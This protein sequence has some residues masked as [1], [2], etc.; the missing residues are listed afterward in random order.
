MRYWKFIPN[1]A[2][3]SVSCPIYLVWSRRYIFDLYSSGDGGVGLSCCNIWKTTYWYFLSIFNH[4]IQSCSACL[5]I[6]SFK[7]NIYLEDNSEPFYISWFAICIK[8]QSVF[9][10]SGR[11][12]DPD[13]KVH[14]ANIRPTWVLSAPDGPHVGPWNL[15]SGETYPWARPS[16]QQLAKYCVAVYNH[17]SQINRHLL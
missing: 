11:F 4:Y 8:F 15:L 7:M 14:G 9:A 12:I 2:N 1:I 6:C 3:L 10:K 17:A 13:S 5:I 16:D